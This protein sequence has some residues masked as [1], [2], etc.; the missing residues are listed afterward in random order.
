MDRNT[1]WSLSALICTDLLLKVVSKELLAEM[2]SSGISHSI[3]SSYITLH[4][5]ALYNLWCY[6]EK[7]VA[8]YRRYPTTLVTPFTKRDCLHPDHAP[9]ALVVIVLLIGALQM[10]CLTLTV[11]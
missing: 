7:V 10:L 5:A 6:H 8:P 3:P 1:E 2:A 11:Q 9:S 4:L